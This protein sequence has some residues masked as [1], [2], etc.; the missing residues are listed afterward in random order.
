MINIVAQTGTCKK[1]GWTGNRDR[2]SVRPG[3]G[4]FKLTREMRAHEMIQ[5]EMSGC[6]HS[7]DH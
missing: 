1:G 7:A 4:I 5:D 6:T 3:S 2:L